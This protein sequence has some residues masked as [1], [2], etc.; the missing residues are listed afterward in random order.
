[1]PASNLSPRAFVVFLGA[2][3]AV[4]PMSIDMY[5]PSL[6]AI[7]ADLAT[8]PDTTHLTIS[9]FLLGFCLGMLVYGPLSDQVGRRPVLLGGLSLYLLASIGCTLATDVHWLAALRFL[10]ALGGGAA[11][12]LARAVVRDHFDAGQSARVLSLMQAVTM[13]APLAAPVLGGYLAGWLG[14]RAVFAVLVLY[15]LLCLTLVSWKLPE[16]LPPERRMKAGIRE[17]FTAYGRVLEDRRSRS[18]ILGGGIAFAG[19]FAYITA[20]P[21][22][23]IQHFGI[24]PQHYGYLFGLNIVG[25]L[26]MALLNAR[27]VRSG[28]VEAVLRS[29]AVV[30]ACAGVALAVV[31]SLDVGGL[32]A[33]VA[34]L[35]GYVSMMGL[36]GAN[37][38]SLLMARHERR[39]G[40]ATAAF[41]VAQFGLGALASSVVG[42]L[43]GPQG[44][45]LMVGLCGVLSLG[46]VT[47]ALARS[48]GADRALPAVSPRRC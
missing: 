46:F 13:L 15:G 5:L 37:S 42:L 8:T 36:I 21:F 1:M 31:T 10:Q 44:L 48:G 23:Y 2:L 30:L 4:G 9:T 19:M 35:F 38:I 17:V 3:V 12:V 6:P 11:A 45:G 22:I 26:C 43:P 34:L 29:G 7:S 41:G 24:A 18:L 20:T 32:A 40:A 27:L 16:S 47:R 14:W 28:K 39:A 33:V 25:I